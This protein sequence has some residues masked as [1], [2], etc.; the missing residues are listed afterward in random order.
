MRLTAPV[1]IDGSNS[2]HQLT[3]LAKF[4]HYTLFSRMLLILVFKKTFK[5]VEEKR[6]FK[7][8][9]KKLKN[10]NQFIL[11]SSCFSFIMLINQQHS[12]NENK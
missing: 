7:T 12:E 3:Q 9:N 1:C 8:A 5:N 4:G 2:N 11:F 6:F 10:N